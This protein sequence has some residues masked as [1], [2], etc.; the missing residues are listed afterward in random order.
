MNNI[1]HPANK[2]TIEFEHVHRDT[3]GTGVD[4]EGARRLVER[5]KGDLQDLLNSSFGLGSNDVIISLQC[6]RGEVI[7]AT[8][9]IGD[10]AVVIPMREV[11]PRIGSPRFDDDAFQPASGFTPLEPSSQSPLARLGFIKPEHP[12]VPERRAQPNPL[13][14][15]VLPQPTFPQV[16][17][18]ETKVTMAIEHLNLAKEVLDHASAQPLSHQE[19]IDCNGQLKQA[20]NYIDGACA[21]LTTANPYLPLSP[22]RPPIIGG[23]GDKQPEL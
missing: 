18:A 9:A 11:L 21:Q 4:I 22:K 20:I 7:A 16:S 17:S 6:V 12:F 19:L 8:N 10:P 13:G 15:D 23:P 5:A 2:P 14:P 3:V 1:N